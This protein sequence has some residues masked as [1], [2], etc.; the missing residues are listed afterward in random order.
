MERV[1]AL[2][3]LSALV[4]SCF[5]SSD[6]STLR[7]LRD[8]TRDRGLRAQDRGD[9]DARR[10]RVD[11]RYLI[12]PG[13]QGAQDPSDRFSQGLRVVDVRFEPRPLGEAQ[14]PACFGA[15]GGLESRRIQSSLHPA[16]G[17]RRA[18]PGVRGS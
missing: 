9:T 11:I 10:L 14:V 18:S 1:T 7:P 17:P 5:P 3:A 6:D 15:V 12:K 4:R 2:L 8:Q 16:V 13:T